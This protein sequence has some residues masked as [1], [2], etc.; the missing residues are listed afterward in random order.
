MPIDRETFD[1]ASEEELSELS[2]ID[3]VLG[4]LA[5]NEDKAFRAR[6]IAQETDLDGGAVSTSLLRLEEQSVVEH[7]GTYW[8]V[9]TETGKFENSDMFARAKALFNDQFK[10]V[11][12]GD[13]ATKSSKVLQK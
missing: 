5:V 13:E 7:K 3:K 9:A 8:A 1:Q 2:T 11:N 12:R 6:E 10:R 4:F